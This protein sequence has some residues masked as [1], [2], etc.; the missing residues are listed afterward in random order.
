MES[1]ASL[2]AAMTHEAN[3]QYCARFGNDKSQLPWEEAP[4]WQRASAINGVNGI[5]DGT[6]KSPE[7]S[8][9]SWMVEKVAAGWKFGAVKDPAAKTHPCLVPYAQLDE[10]QRKKDELFR[11]I[12]LALKG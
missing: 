6:I 8:H 10:Y 1:L 11:A 12:V 2:I 7:Q 4:E 9:E 5:L 3:R